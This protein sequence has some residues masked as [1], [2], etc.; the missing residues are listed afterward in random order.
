M[1]QSVPT[2]TTDHGLRTIAGYIVRRT[3]PGT[4]L[5]H[6]DCAQIDDATNYGLAVEIARAERVQ[7]GQYAVIDPVYTCGCRGRG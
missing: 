6:V 3:F 5:A 2:C 7:A 1:S 4:G